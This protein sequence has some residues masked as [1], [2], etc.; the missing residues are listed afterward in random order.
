[1]EPQA[2][3]NNRLSSQQSDVRAAAL[4]EILQSGVDVSPHINA[5]AACLT[6]PFEPLRILA[7]LLLARIGAPAA[8]FLALALSRRQPDGFRATAAAILAG[9]GPSAAAAVPGLC[10]CLDSPDETLRKAAGIALAKIGEPAVPA[11]RLILPLSNHEAVSAAV[12]ALALIGRPAESVV[13]ELDALAVTSPPKIQ[14]ACAAAISNITGDAER[15]L[16]ILIKALEGPDPSIRQTAAEKIAALGTAAHPAIPD[17][18]RCTAD[19]DEGIRTAALLTLGRIQ[20]PPDQAVPAAAYRLS[21]PAA[22]VRYSAAIVLANYGANARP[23]LQSLYAC[24]RDPV[25]KVTKAA[26][27]AINKINIPTP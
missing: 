26:A 5:V 25:E 23:A 10:R 11:L 2:S 15:G 7:L 8:E 19:P 22:E 1:M 24:L 16:P 21:D 18:L 20:A 3:I 27:A 4:A 9:M 13:R 12:D 6:D 14:L 17:L